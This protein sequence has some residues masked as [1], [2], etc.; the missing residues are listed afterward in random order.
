MNWNPALPALAAAL[1]LLL[2][3]GGGI[4]GSP[5]APPTAVKVT[6]TSYLVLEVAW[7]PSEGKIDFYELQGRFAPEPWGLASRLPKETGAGAVC[8]A[9]FTGAGHLRLLRN[10]GVVL[11]SRWETE[12]SAMDF[13]DGAW[14]PAKHLA[15]VPY[16]AVDT[17]L[18]ASRDGERFAYED[19]NSADR[20]EVVLLGP[21]GIERFQV[22]RGRFGFAEGPNG[23]LWILAYAPG[24]NDG[25]AGPVGASG[26]YRCYFEKP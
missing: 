24:K 8:A 16:L 3:C 7:Q 2:A 12:F 1:P 20:H 9:E 18:V 14:T 21:G 15:T 5:V 17:S 11:A 13:K 26:T 19:S 10:R 22:G 23:R 25:T 4:G 6:Q